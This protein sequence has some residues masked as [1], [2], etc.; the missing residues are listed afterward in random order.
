MKKRWIALVLAAAVVGLPSWG[1]L[2]L[3][4]AG[5]A[6]AGETE[7]MQ[8]ATRACV[9]AAEEAILS[10]AEPLSAAVEQLRADIAETAEK[11]MRL[12]PPVQI[13][14]GWWQS[15]YRD[16]IGYVYSP[17]TPI[18]Y[19]IAYDGDNDY[20]LHHDLYGN[21][22]VYGTIFLDARANRDFTSQSNMLYGHHMA[23][24]TMFA[25]IS[26]YKQQWYYDAHPYFYLYTNAGTY[27]VDLFAG[28]IVPG[29]HE[30]FNTSF[31]D[32][33]LARF[34]SQSTFNAGRGIPTGRI[35]GM[36]TCSYEA[37]NYRF[38]VLGEM[39]PLTEGNDQ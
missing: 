28:L 4:G 3:T 23:D 22:S 32:A 33:D 34:I 12:T 30:V 7:S 37:D 11:T 17:G 1:V 18:S 8:D 31:S 38:V 26:G 39:T 15:H 14:L 24:G 25:S 10:A 27:R 13:D 36:C 29:E 5:T 35:V 21:Y 9:C 20:Y 6:A 19:P 16:I 2:A